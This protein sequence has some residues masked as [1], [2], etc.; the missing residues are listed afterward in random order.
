MQ[1]V[2]HRWQIVKVGLDDCGSSMGTC[3]APPAGSHLALSLRQARQARELLGRFAPFGMR[4]LMFCLTASDMICECFPAETLKLD[5]G[6]SLLRNNKG[7]KRRPTAE[8]EVFKACFLSSRERAR[9]AVESRT[10]NQG[11]G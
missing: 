2:L 8:D 6:L 1:S 7:G 5:V 11:C 10:G 3:F 4:V 9:T